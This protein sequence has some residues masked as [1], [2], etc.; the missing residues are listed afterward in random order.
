[1]FFQVG[2][3]KDLI[4]LSPLALHF[5]ESLSLEPFSMPRDVAYIV[6]SPE[7]EYLNSSVKNFFK[8]L[9]STYEVRN[10]FCAP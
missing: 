10:Y 8:T 2:H 6:V 1:M 4:S 5:W 3:E 7:S 9:S